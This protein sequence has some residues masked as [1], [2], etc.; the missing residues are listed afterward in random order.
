MKLITI[1]CSLTNLFGFSQTLADLLNVELI[2]LS[3]PASSNQLQVNRLHELILSQQVDKED[4]VYWQI[5]GINRKNGRLQMDRFAE[6]D[7]IQKDQFTKPNHHYVIN[8]NINIFDKKNRID[9]LCNSPAASTDVDSNQDLQMLLAT[10]ILMSH[11]TPKLIVT[12]GWKNIMLPTHMVA[13][14]KQLTDHEINFIEETYLDYTVNNNLE[15]FDDG[16][17]GSG[18]AGPYLKEVIQPKLVSLG[19]I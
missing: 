1:G 8:E 9:L 13:F 18:A 6:I 11:V 5:T 3:Y 17:P 2:D 19:W 15:M 10:I 4:I 14:K 12:F 7:K 16:H